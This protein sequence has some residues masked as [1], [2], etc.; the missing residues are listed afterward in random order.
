MSL[1]ETRKPTAP[2]PPR[3]LFSPPP[4]KRERLVAMTA[5]AWTLAHELSH[6]LTC[7]TRRIRA[8]ARQLERCA[9]GHQDLLGLIEDAAKE[10]ARAHEI[11]GRMNSFLVNGRVAARREGLLSMLDQA[12]LSLRVEDCARLAIVTTIAPDAHHVFADRIQIEQAFANL[13]V[14][15]CQALAGRES[16]RVS[17]SATRRGDDV[18]VQ[19]RDNGRGLSEDAAAH[20]FEPF[21]TTREGGLGLG[22][23]I[24]RT[25]IEAH[26][27]QLWA[28]RPA[29]GALFGLSLPAAG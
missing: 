25:I 8:C 29:S 15:A 17:I 6:P 10:T 7:A 1:F 26:G 12:R 18:V 21:F 3:N 20:L 23:A 19:I 4:E 9:E 22:L 5:M 28:E 13:L 16:G 14:N 27:G 11:I 2:P 24:S